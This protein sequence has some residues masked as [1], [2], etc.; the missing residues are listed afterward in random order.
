MPDTVAPKTK[1]DEEIRQLAIDV[2]EGRVFGSWACDPD[3]WKLVFMPL[4]LLGPEDVEGFRDVCSVY[5]YID[6]AGP[7][8]CNGY[9]MFMSCNMLYRNDC[10]RLYDAITEYIRIRSEFAGRVVS[11]PVEE[12]S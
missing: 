11:N 9:P 7:R 6:K 5:E 2:V 8:T 3:S 10:R 4:G 1:T 12:Q